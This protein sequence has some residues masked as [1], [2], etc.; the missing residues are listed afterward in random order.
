MYTGGACAA[1]LVA[2]PQLAITKELVESA[3]H[4]KQRFMVKEFKD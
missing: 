3:Q 2:G 1:L 4:D